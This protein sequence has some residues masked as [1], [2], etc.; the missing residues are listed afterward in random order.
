MRSVRW[1]SGLGVGVARVGSCGERYR[2]MWNHSDH[3][4]RAGSP[5]SS[6]AAGD[7]SAPPRPGC[8]PRWSTPTSVPDLVLGTSIGAINGVAVAADPTPRGSVGSARS[9]KGGAQRGLRR[10]HRGPRPALRCGPHEPALERAAAASAPGGG[11]ERTGSRTCRCRSSAL[12][13]ASRPRRR[14]G[15]TAGRST[16]RSPPPARCRGCSPR[17]RSTVG[18]TWTVAWSIPSP[19]AV[20][21]T[22][23]PRSSTSS[24]SVGSR[25]RWSPHVDLTRWRSSRSRSLVATASPRHGRPSRGVQVHVLPTGAEPIRFN[26]VR[27]LRYRDFS[28]VVGADRR[29]IGGGDVVRLR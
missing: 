9:G 29:G 27:Q 21:S 3:G 13:R 19:C 12:P 25:S 18:T 14:R 20:R 24:R 23:A 17:S 28:G 10:E 8:S 7:V 15:S 6:S 11:R 1:T 4:D 16:R 2:R 5:P 22:W 26:D